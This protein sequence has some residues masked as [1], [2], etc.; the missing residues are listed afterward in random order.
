ML[1][2]FSQ[3]GIPIEHDRVQSGRPPSRLEVQQYYLDHKRQQYRDLYKDV[4]QPYGMPLGEL[5]VGLR[6]SLGSVLINLGR[7]MARETAPRREALARR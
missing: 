2:Y 7:W 1:P 4:R 5:I 6:Q 3:S